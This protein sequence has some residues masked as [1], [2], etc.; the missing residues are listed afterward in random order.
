MINQDSAHKRPYQG[1]KRRGGRPPLDVDIVAIGDAV[2]EARAGGDETITA[3]A[4]RFGVSRGWIHAN[5][6]PA[7]GY[8]S[9]AKSEQSPPG[10]ADAGP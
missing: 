2:R 8:L 6:Y 7:L 9:R 4:R 3:I 1:Y 5:V 10:P